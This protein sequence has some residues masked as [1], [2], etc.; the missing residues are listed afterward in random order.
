MIYLD[1]EDSHCPLK[2]SIKHNVKVQLS[3]SL[4]GELQL[5]KDQ[6]MGK[7]VVPFSGKSV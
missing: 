6:K 4:I 7:R 5:P 2:E 1:Q 3:Q